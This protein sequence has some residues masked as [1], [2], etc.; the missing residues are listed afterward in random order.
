MRRA[1]GR[2]IGWALIVCLSG[3]CS[4][5]FALPS[6]KYEPKSPGRLSISV[7]NG[8]RVLV[9]D[10]RAVGLGSGT[11]LSAVADS[12]EAYEAACRYRRRSILTAVIGI[13]A[14]ACTGWFLP[15]YFDQ[16]EDHGGP[17]FA[18]R[19]TLYSCGSAFLLALLLDHINQ[20]NLYDAIN[21]YNDHLAAKEAG[22]AR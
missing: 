3:G 18:T 1:V 8:G 13:P 10:G 9:K 12:P 17:S 5:S 15:Y 6:A 7:R 20:E 21:I 4:L 14:G 2:A 16:V 19:I 11:L 22:A